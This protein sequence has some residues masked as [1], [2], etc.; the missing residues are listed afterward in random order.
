M[1]GFLCVTNTFSHIFEQ[2]AYWCSK[3]RFSAKRLYKVAKDLSKT[4]RDIIEKHSAFSSFLNISPFSVLNELID[5]IAVHT[6][7]EL[8]EF[9]YNGKRIVFTKEMM[10]KAFGVRPGSRPLELLTKS[11]QSDLHD[12]YKGGLTRL[13]IKD[14]VQ[15][16]KDHADTDED[17]V[18]KTWDLL[19]CASVL[20]PGTNN[21]MCLEYL[22]SMDDPKKPTS[23]IGMGTFLI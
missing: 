22:G 23:L 12:R 8:R 14:A 3:D 5:F 16:L 15:M 2:G 17:S 1:L 10:S 19:C 4:K 21:M 6:S 18:I 20:H 7:V 11:V 9:N 13:P